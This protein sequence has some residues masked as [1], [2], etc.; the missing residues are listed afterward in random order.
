MQSICSVQLVLSPSSCLFKVAS[1]SFS[2]LFYFGML[3]VP[4]MYFLMVSSWPSFC[5]LSFFHVNKVLDR[6]FISLSVGSAY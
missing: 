4:F 5:S 3:L 2:L 1:S 6:T